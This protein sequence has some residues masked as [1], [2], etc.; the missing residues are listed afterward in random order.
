MNMIEASAGDGVNVTYEGG[1]RNGTMSL[2]PCPGIRINVTSD[3]QMGTYGLSHE[4]A[5]NVL[6]YMWEG[7]AK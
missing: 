2:L 3:D 4:G 6:V 7:W 1:P 5:G